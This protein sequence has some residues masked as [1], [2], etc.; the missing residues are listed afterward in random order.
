[1][2]YIIVCHSGQ[3]N[4]ERIMNKI[5][6]LTTLFW[7]VL[8]A[9]AQQQATVYGTLVNAETGQAIEFA[10]IILDSGDAGTAAG[11]LTDNTGYF[12]L[13]GL[14]AGDYSIS[15]RQDNFATRREEVLIFAGNDNYNLGRLNLVPLGD[16][17]EI[18]VLGEQTLAGPSID[19]R[20]YNLDN[21]I[22]QSTGSLLDVM[23]TLPGV[24]VEQDGRI[25]LRGSDRVVILID[26][27]QSSLTGFGN[28]A[29]LDSIPAGN[30]ASVEIINNP[31]SRF[32]S[33]G[34]AG[35]V[36]ITY[37]EDNSQGLS[38]DVGLTYGVG[39][40]SKRKDD[41]PTDLGSFSQNQKVIPGANLS[42][43]SDK[44]R[45]YLNAEVLMQDDLPNN[46][47]TS[48][49]Y[50][51]GRITYSQVPENREQ[52]QYIINGGMDWQIN[53]SNLLTVSAIFDYE[54]HEDNAEVPFI[55][56]LDNER[57]RFWFWREEEV[58]GF[59]NGNIEYEHQLDGPGHLISASLQ[60][61]R[62]WE[63]EDYFL[64]D[65][66]ILRN[67]SDSTHLKAKEN[68][69]PIQIDYVRPLRNG[70]IETG[71]K[72]QKRWIPIT[73]DVVRG[74][75]TIIYEG[76][77]DNSEWGET[78]TSS[79]LNLVYETLNFGVEGGL[80]VENTEVYYDLPAEN[81][82]YEG[83]DSYDYFKVFPNIRVSYKIGPNNSIAAYLGRRVDR[84]G[85]AELR[86]FPKYDDPELL[87]VGNPYLRPQFTDSI[88]L[89]Y[90]HLWDSGSVI[91][92]LYN[93]D[94]EDPFMR[95]FDIDNSNPDYNIVNRIYQNVGSAAQNGLE[96]IF[97]QDIS[98]LWQLTGSI[99]WYKN[100]VDPYRTEILFPVIR[101]FDVIASEDDTWNLN[102]NNQVF[103]PW[104]VRMQL[105]YT[106]YAERNIAQG[107][108]QARSSLDL[109]LSKQVFEDTTELVLS[110]TDMFND[111]GIRQDI[112]GS[113]FKAVYENYFET[114]VVS[115]GFKY[116]LQ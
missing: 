87:K 18:V 4:I 93:R 57:Y 35:I 66:S 113:G 53:D 45:Y 104:G 28:Q 7:I 13:S 56:A 96:L 72:Y 19:N 11:I 78:I 25:Q 98:D 47:F 38:G 69:L 23:R 43:N 80:R 54:R 68:T 81:I 83:S 32:D 60:Y 44:R 115:L 85:E 82:Y 77:G 5:V 29:G 88:E 84:P 102:L 114:Q 12:E 34:M 52:I 74:T 46:E 61:T 10:E 59:F 21:N 62:G 33:A 49:F 65:R 64:N 15:I 17:E 31:S 76:L 2:R 3:H 8:P 92:S 111:F 55:N 1:M 37:K 100:T 9:F 97:S 101:P 99:N 110:V 108:E 27:K 89:A 70:R 107:R 112:A 106:Y 50:D 51:D 73:Y 48:R 79:Y 24:T 22:A 86:I 20:I 26:G 58:T 41:L 30:I 42:Y 6:I 90:E 63:D 40:L 103:L 105:S 91:A 36:N 94:I 14:P 16:I 109:G 116:T 71:A 67:A 75:N 39:M 95:V